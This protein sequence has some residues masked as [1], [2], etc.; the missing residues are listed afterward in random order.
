MFIKKGTIP[1]VFRITNHLYSQADR[2]Y[3]N[4]KELGSTTPLSSS[5]RLWKGYQKSLAG[6]SWCRDNAELLHQ[7]QLVNVVPLFDGLSVGDTQD[8]NICHG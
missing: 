7:T 5:P 6:L 4:H 1:S 2:T 8:G 3:R